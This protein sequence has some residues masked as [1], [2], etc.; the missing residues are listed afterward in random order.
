MAFALATVRAVDHNKIAKVK[1]ILDPSAGWSGRT[2]AVTHC[3]EDTTHN[4]R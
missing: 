3:C 4:T 2:T 1:L